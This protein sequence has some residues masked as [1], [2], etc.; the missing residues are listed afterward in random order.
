MPGSRIRTPRL[1]CRGALPPHSEALER[2]GRSAERALQPPG[3]VSGSVRWA[4]IHHVRVRGGSAR[5]CA[6]CPH[7]NGDID[8]RRYAMHRWPSIYPEKEVTMAYMAEEGDASCCPPGED[9]PKD[10]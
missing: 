6:T 9:C 1:P 3:P 7:R 2:G 4:C 8:G 10:C 5:P